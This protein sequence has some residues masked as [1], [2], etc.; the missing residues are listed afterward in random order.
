MTQNPRD[1]WLMA[2]IPAVFTMGIYLWGWGRPASRALDDA[3]AKMVESDKSAPRMSDL[4]TK[5]KSVEDFSDK[6]ADEKERALHITQNFMPNADARA[7]AI[8]GLSSILTAKGLTL[9]KS[10][11]NASGSKKEAIT[12]VEQ[13]CKKQHI[14]APQFW[15]VEMIGSYQQMLDTLQMLSHSTDFIIPIVIEMNAHPAV[16]REKAPDLTDDP[17]KR[18]ALTLWI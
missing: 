18:W 10:A 12:D 6:L 2:V 8:N 14:P 16:G 4:L 11:P 1:R 13:L 3:R 17:D 5:Q 15:Q 7:K 9:V